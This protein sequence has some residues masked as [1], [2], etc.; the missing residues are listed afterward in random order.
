MTEEPEKSLAGTVIILVQE[1]RAGLLCG[2][3]PITA[4]KV[5]TELWLQ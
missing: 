1:N 3:K 4:V 5:G 2:F